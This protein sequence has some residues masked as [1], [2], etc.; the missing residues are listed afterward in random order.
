MRRL[1]SLIFLLVLYISSTFSQ[2]NITF[3]FLGTD[4][5][6]LSECEVYINGKLEGN[7]KDNGVYYFNYDSSEKKYSFL[8][9]NL[10]E[11]IS[12]KFE[13]NT[14]N[15]NNDLKKDFIG[16]NQ[17]GAYLDIE[18]MSAGL[19]E[20]MDNFQD[21][22]VT[23][24][25]VPVFSNG[26]TIF[27]TKA[28]NVISASKDHLKEIIDE[29]S[30]RRIRIHAVVNIL[31][32]GSGNLDDF[33]FKNLLM[34]N[35]NG[36]WN[37]G[38]EKN[39]FFV[40]PA[41]PETIKI[42]TEIVRELSINYRKLSGI[43]FD[44]LRFKKGKIENY[45]NEDFGFDNYSVETFKNTTRL[46]PF[47]IKPDTTEGSN[48]MRW[49]E[50][51]ENLLLNLAVKL[52]AAIKD[53]NSTIKITISADPN[54][55][56]QRG[57]DLTCENYY[58]IGE[59]TRIDYF[60]MKINENSYVQDFKA[61]E[62][63]ITK[64]LPMLEGEIANKNKFD[65]IFKYIIDNKYDYFFGVYDTDVFKSKPNRQKMLSIIFR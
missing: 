14:K 15:G 29:C 4:G 24:L 21:A 10:T 55:I 62:P 11:N 1:F 41:N 37:E 5:M 46:D 44:F 45:M 34:L 19:S 23:D 40:S 35:R 9:N 31:N 17:L 42:L 48:W 30:K 12:K 3:K 63:F 65:E 64:T 25:F 53:T 7:T 18:N 58:E 33:K 8:V 38:S 28:P 51:K 2:N 56:Y 61:V 27:P 39:E 16:F 60:L 22:G 49:V 57:K 50:H 20:I 54:Y 36:K 26:K 6:P 47:S 43:S 32:W 13:I 52:I 59:F